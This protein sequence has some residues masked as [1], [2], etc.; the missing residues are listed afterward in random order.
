MRA[1]AVEMH[2]D[3]SQQPFFAETYGGLDDTPS[4]EQWVVTLTVGQLFSVATLFG[5]SYGVAMVLVAGF[6]M[7]AKKMDGNW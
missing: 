5:E 7:A 6:P 2:M 4:N 3:I 1:C